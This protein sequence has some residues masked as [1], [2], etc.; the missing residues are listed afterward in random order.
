MRT[1]LDS[2]MGKMSFY[3]K[4]TMEL[5]FRGSHHRDLLQGNTQQYERVAAGV[6]QDLLGPTFDVYKLTLSELYYYFFMAKANTLGPTWQFPWECQNTVLKNDQETR[7]SHKNSSVYNLS[8]LTPY[9]LPADHKPRTYPLT[10]STVG[11]INVGEEA[12][13]IEVTL[14]PLTLEQEFEILDYFVEN[15]VS[16]DKVYKDKAYD[17]AI[18]RAASALTS[19]DPIF[20][21]ASVEDKILLLDENSA[22]LKAEMMRD[23]LVYDRVGYPLR[24]KDTCKGCKREVALQLPFLAGLVVYD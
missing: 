20:A 16:R 8:K 2:P 22:R 17:L 18:R 13:S 15:G 10:L 4:V 23:I 11:K 5:E 6:V 7:C 1:Q 9:Q 24:M 14:K 3:P 12:R 21:G 19:D